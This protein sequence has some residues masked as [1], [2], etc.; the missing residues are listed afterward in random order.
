MIVWKEL[1]DQAIYY[2]EAMSSKGGGAYA[3]PYISARPN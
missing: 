3:K 2:I 1:I